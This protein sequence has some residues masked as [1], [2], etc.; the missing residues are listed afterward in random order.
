VT[1]QA[2]I[3]NDP[4]SELIEEGFDVVLCSDHVRVGYGE[5]ACD[6]SYEGLRTAHDL[7]IVRGLVVALLAGVMRA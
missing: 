2:L 7:G 3:A 6:V 1:S 4:V 5:H